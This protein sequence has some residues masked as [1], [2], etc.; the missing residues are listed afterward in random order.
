M[1]LR[2]HRSGDAWTAWPGRI[3]ITARVTTTAPALAAWLLAGSLPS[4]LGSAVPEGSF[5]HLTIED[6]LPHS[7]VRAI[8]KAH[9]GFMWFATARGLVRYDGARLV[10]YRHDPDDPGSLPFGEP[11]CLFEDHDRRLWV[12]TASSRWAGIGVLDRVTGRFT[13]YLAERKF[14]R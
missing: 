12:G 6:G 10:V 14:E 11:T 8:L 3:R 4:A 1:A 7:Y 2:P 9:D 13:R 5:S